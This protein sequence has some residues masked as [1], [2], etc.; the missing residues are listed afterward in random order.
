MQNVAEE[1]LQSVSVLMGK[2]ADPIGAVPAT[3]G[4][5]AVNTNASGRVSQVVQNRSN[6]SL[7][8]EREVSGMHVSMGVP[9]DAPLVDLAK[10]VEVVRDNRGRCILCILALLV[11]KSA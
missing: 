5:E 10:A 8:K 4:E 6:R 7:E 9:S 11:G 2:V 3:L 1:E